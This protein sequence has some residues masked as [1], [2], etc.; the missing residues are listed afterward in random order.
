MRQVVLEAKTHAGKNKLAKTADASIKWDGN[1]NVAEERSRVLFSS[2]P[3]PWFLLTP[4]KE[5]GII[6]VRLSRWVHATDDANFTVRSN[7]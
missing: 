6:A 1:W 2:K 7:K 5:D 4:A 3:G